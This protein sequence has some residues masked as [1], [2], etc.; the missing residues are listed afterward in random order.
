MEQARKECILESAVHAFRRHGFKK[1]SVDEIARQ[2]GVAKGTVYLACESKEDLY[3]QA[4]H[5]E[6]REWV[7]ESAKRIDPRVPADELLPQLAFATLAEIDSKPLVKALL[8][9]ECADLLPRWRAR[10]TE[11]RELCSANVVEVLKLGT[12]QGRFRPGLDVEA[13]GQLMLDLQIATLVFHTTGPEQGR[14][15]RLQRRA[16]AAFDLILEGLRPRT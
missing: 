6:V 7:A 1:A 14:D 5:R 8:S 11:L 15:E 13:V 3:Y 2:A 16:A 10:F 12:R 4:L 9:G